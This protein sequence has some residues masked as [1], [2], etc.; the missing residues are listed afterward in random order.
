MAEHSSNKK[1]ANGRSQG[2]QFSVS[3]SSGAESMEEWAPGL[4][5]SQM[6]SP[7]QVQDWNWTQHEIN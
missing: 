3:L 4:R 2:M 5:D 7:A 1:S 6:T